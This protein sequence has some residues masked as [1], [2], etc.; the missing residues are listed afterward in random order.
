MD[1]FEY[2]L[3]ARDGVLVETFPQAC[4]NGHAL[5]PGRMI[6]GWNPHPDESVGGMMRTWECRQCGQKIYGRRI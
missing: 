1:V 4:P 2:S 3:Y 5:G 6:V